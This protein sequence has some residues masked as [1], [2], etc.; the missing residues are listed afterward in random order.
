MTDTS[1]ATSAVVQAAPGRWIGAG[2]AIIRE[3]LG[4]FVLMTLI[5]LGLTA[6]AGATIVGPLVVGGPLLA[7]MFMAI[8]RRMQEGRTD[9]MDVFQGFNRFIDALLICLVVSVFSLAGLAL[10]IVPFFVVGALY[11]FSLLFVVDRN[12][13]F[14]EAME[15]SRKTAGRELAGHVVFFLVLC[16][17][18]LIGLMLAGIGL[19]FTLPVSLAAIAVAYNEVVGFQQQPHKPTGPIVIP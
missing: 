16:L 5:V 9:L 2:W 15:A 19:V 11:M 8:R 1:S 12:L 14:W 6:V 10:C 13:G 3:D 18:N 7:G 4:N 17:L